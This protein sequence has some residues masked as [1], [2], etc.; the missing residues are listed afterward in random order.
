MDIY[1]HTYQFSSIF[2]GQMVQSVPYDHTAS[3]EASVYGLFLQIVI[4]IG[5]QITLV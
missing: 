2:V 5:W 1:A 4:S 3:I